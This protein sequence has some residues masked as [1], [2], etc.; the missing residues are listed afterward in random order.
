M[1]LSECCTVVDKRGAVKEKN[2]LRIKGYI[3]SDKS[4]LDITSVN[5][6]DFFVSACQK[7][8]KAACI[9]IAEYDELALAFKERVFN[10]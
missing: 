2:V 8:N 1:L 4:A 5:K 10:G 6:G 7:R 9:G 3:V